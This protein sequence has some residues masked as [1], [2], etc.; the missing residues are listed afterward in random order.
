LENGV[1]EK[2]R[3]EKLTEAI[4]GAAIEVHRALGPGLLESAYLTCLKREMDLVGLRWQADVPVPVEYKGVKLDCG[5]RIDLIVEDTVVV[6]LKAVEKLLPVH[7]AQVI[8]YLRLTGKP[9][10]LLINFNVPLLKDGIKRLINP[11]VTL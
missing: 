1:T 11:S 5:Y 7:Q 9:V 8:T 3:L 6:E 4:I 2:Q 10:G